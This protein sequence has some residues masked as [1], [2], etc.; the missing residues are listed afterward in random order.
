MAAVLPENLP[1]AS[2]QLA[3]LVVANLETRVKSTW[4]PI[5]ITGASGDDRGAQSSRSARLKPTSVGGS[6]AADQGQHEDGPVRL[7][8]VP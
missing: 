5:Q 3:N 2:L 7:N 6:L 4:I 1:L 8:G